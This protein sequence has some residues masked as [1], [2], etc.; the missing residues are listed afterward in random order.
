MR[1]LQ[2]IAHGEPSDVEIAQ[3]IAFLSP[4]EESFITGASCLVNDGKTA[5]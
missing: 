4:D 5:Q 2:P 3:A 1:Q